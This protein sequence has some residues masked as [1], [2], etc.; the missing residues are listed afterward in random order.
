VESNADVRSGL[1]GVAFGLILPRLT[2]PLWLCGFKFG[3]IAALVGLLVVPSIKGLP[4]RS[5]WI[6]LNWVRSFLINGSGAS[7]WDLLYRR[8]WREYRSGLDRPDISFR[9]ETM[10]S[11]HDE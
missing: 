11:G 1:Y 9:G 2:A 6:L 10:P 4:V 3:I 5:G 7:V 8:C